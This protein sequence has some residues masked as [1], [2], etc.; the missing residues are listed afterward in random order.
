[1]GRI[2]Y[3]AAL[4]HSGS[5]L[6]G[7][8]L[9]THPSATCLG[10]IYPALTRGRGQ[11]NDCSCGRDVA[12]CP[13]W[14]PSDGRQVPDGREAYRAAYLELLKRSASARTGDTIVVDVSKRLAGLQPLL[15]PPVGDVRVIWLLK[16]VRSFVYS[17]LTRANRPALMQK[18]GLRRFYTT[19]VPY[20]I[21]QWRIGN[22]RIRE[23]LRT[24]KVPFFQLG[25]EELCFRPE[26][27]MER[28]CAFLEIPYDPC[29]IRPDPAR[30]H[31]IR[32]NRVR[33]D[34]GR[35]DGVHYDGAW[36]RSTRIAWWMDAMAPLMNWNS[37]EV[38]S[39][40]GHGTGS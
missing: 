7:L 13:V 28:I 17:Q 32:G 9:G 36:L 4:S 21:L 35:L 1:M 37:R 18:D 10:E 40:T 11:W 31:V 2:V 22:G 12:Q 39:N 38:Y 5:T 27:M 8:M 19:T 3:I 30:S 15:D 23:F 14:G 6:L 33:R 29:V 26:S 16:D 24:R 20:N 25:Y 34:P